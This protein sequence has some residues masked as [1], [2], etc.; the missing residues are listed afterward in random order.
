[1]RKVLGIIALIMAITVGTLLI[2]CNTKETELTDLEKMQ[3]AYE[4]IVGASKIDEKIEIKKGDL[5]VYE[6]KKG[7]LRDG[8]E[9]K[10]TETEKTLNPVDEAYD[11]AYTE[12][13]DEYSLTAADE[14]TP[15]IKLE[16]SYFAS[17]SFEDGF[18]GKVKAGYEKELLGITEE[19][20]SVGNM[21][22]RFSVEGE[23]VIEIKI[24]YTSGENK[25]NITLKIE[26]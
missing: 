13:T 8:A 16:E 20:G 7:I 9:F 6:L 3:A 17:V 14:F 22:L 25:I 18:V 15:S 12:T 19:I 5:L 10:V 11:S 26:Y 23:K 24:S 4:Q 1:M 21:E 2:A